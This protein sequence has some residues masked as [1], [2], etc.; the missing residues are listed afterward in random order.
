ML[1]VAISK[2]RILHIL[3]TKS[4]FLNCLSKRPVTSMEQRNKDWVLT[5]YQEYSGEQDRLG[6]DLYI[7]VLYCLYRELI[8]C[9]ET[10]KKVWIINLTVCIK[11]SMKERIKN[12]LN[13][14]KASNNFCLKM[15]EN[16]FSC[17]CPKMGSQV[18]LSSS[19]TIAGVSILCLQDPG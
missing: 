19:S 17:N 13:A 9:L 7:L 18:L 12:W 15:I 4:T 8:L 5:K 10:E 14:T 16:S 1:F 2:D 3:G 11:D 6:L